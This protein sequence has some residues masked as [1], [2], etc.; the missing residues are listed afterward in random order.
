MKSGLEVGSEGRVCL[1]RRSITFQSDGDTPS[2]R[3]G[4]PCVSLA[5][6][7]TSVQMFH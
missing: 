6:Q 5:E 4:V 7:D 3:A 2:M 1:G